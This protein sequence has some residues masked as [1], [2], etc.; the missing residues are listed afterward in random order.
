MTRAKRWQAGSDISQPTPVASS[1]SFSY[2]PPI[3]RIEM[4][5][6]MCWQ[7]FAS[8]FPGCDTSLRTAAT[9]ATS[10]DPPW[11]AWANGRSKSSSDRTRRKASTFCPADGW[12]NG[13]LP[14][15]G[16]VVGSR[17]TGSDPSPRQQ[18]GPP[19]PQSA[20]SH[21]EPQA[22]VR[23]EKLPNPALTCFLTSSA[24][25]RHR[26]DSVI[27]PEYDNPVPPP[28]PVR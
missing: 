8:G 23:I 21:A 27:R 2:T 26:H 19:S 25:I 28:A 16:A 15:S 12:T 20:C 11:L 3:F 13:L 4:G 17:K 14:G 5:L 10:C 9:L 6:S 22:T 24:Q 18:L 7:P 1:S